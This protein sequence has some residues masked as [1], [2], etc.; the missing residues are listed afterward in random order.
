MEG[1]TLAQVLQREGMLEPARGRRGGRGA[2]RRAR[3]GLV[4]RDITPGNV[5]VSS[6]GLVKVA[7]FGIAKL[8]AAPTLTGSGMLPGTAGYLSPEYAPGCVL[9]ALLTGAPPFAGDSPLAVASQHVTEQP[10]PPSRRNPR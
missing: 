8:A 1:E 4:H 10:E 6:S 3:A 9:Y 5:L 2:G 7:D